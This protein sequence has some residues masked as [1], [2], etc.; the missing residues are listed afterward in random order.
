MRRATLP[1]IA[2]LLGQLGLIAGFVVLWQHAS[3]NDWI[4]PA[5]WS[6]P[7]DVWRQI[8]D[9]QHQGVLW[10]SLK[11]TMRIFIVGYLWGTAIGVI[12]GILIGTNA[13]FREISEPF[14]LF[15]NAMPRLVLLPLFIVW[16]GFGYGPRYVYIA[17]VIVMFVAVNVAAGLRE[18][19]SDIVDNVRLMGGHRRH[20]VQQV[21][22]PSISL[23]VSSTARVTV[24]Y[25]FN[26]AIA[27][28]FI[29]A[30]SGLGYLI[31]RGQNT[32]RSKQIIAAMVIVAALALVI[33]G[34]LASIERRARR[35]TPP[36]R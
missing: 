6:K 22:V 7:T 2:I 31:V 8:L 16:F 25:A 35:W 1:R 26:A 24:G 19:R 12:L 10:S 32:F 18:V 9:W 13:W 33:D 21:Y 20:L 28:E 17:L 23:W 4:N 34:V 5:F 14:V 30:S 29:G 36:R 27:A 15:L 3:T 11:E